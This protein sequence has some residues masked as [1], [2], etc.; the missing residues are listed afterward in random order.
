MT[1]MCCRDTLRLRAQYRQF[2]YEFID[3]HVRSLA[4][5]FWF[6]ASLHIT[7]TRTLSKSRA[8]IPGSF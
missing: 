3:Y 2:S 7:Q 6:I 5:D 1:K 4:I 8:S